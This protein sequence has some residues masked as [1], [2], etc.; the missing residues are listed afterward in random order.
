[1]TIN[2][3]DAEQPREVAEATEALR[4]AEQQLA[5]VRAERQ[6]REAAVREA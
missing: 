4:T 5:D 3:P 6:A 1:M 2:L